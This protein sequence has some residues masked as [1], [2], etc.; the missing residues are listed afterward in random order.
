MRKQPTAEQREKARERRQKMRS[1]AAEISKMSLGERMEL[2]K[3]VPVVTIEGRTLS[4]FNCCF[5]VH[6]N[7]SAT[8]VGGFRQWKAAGRCVRKGEHGMALWIPTG[9][10]KSDQDDAQSIASDSEGVRFVLGT[11]FD[12]SQ[13]QESNAAVV[14]SEGR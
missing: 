2:A 8:V 5:V 9:T 12:V 14:E 3:R 13:T 10:G 11:V 4:P 7:S 1:L 6:Q